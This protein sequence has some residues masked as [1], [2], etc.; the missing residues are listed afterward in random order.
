MEREGRR[1]GERGS[2]R[3]KRGKRERRGQAV[4]SIVGWATLLLQ[5][6]CAE[7]HTWPGN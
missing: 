6:N 2:K 5:G 1:E 4:P 3:S 7:K